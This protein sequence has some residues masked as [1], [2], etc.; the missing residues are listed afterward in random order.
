MTRRMTQEEKE[1]LEGVAETMGV[2]PG[3]LYYDEKGVL[4]KKASGRVVGGVGPSTSFA[5]CELTAANRASAR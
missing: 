5:H 3:S 4:R 2:S 1:F